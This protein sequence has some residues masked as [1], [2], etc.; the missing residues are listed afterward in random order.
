[1]TC[2]RDIFKILGLISQLAGWN[3]IS[4][5]CPLFSVLSLLN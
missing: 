4:V 1:M 2:L 3:L 5:I